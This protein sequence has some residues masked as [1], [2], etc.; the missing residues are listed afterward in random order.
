MLLLSPL[1]PRSPSESEPHRGMTTVRDSFCSNVFDSEENEQAV[2]E[3]EDE[4]LGRK[5][6]EKGCDSGGDDP[7]ESPGD[8]PVES[9]GDTSEPSRVL[10]NTSDG[11]LKFESRR[12][13][14]V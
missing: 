12:E 11:T 4:L 13:S 10:I 6:E 2:D 1:T 9:P 8:D 3:E 5:A 7:V 14:H